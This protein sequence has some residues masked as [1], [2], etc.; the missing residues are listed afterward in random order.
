M[1]DIDKLRQQLE[2]ILNRNRDAR[3][4]RLVLSY[5]AALERATHK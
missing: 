1:N 2:T 4:L 3:F 5:V